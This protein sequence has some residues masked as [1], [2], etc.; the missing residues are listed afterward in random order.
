MRSLGISLSLI[1]IMGCSGPEKMQEQQPNNN[2]GT[3]TQFSADIWADNWFSLDINDQFIFEDSVPITTEKSFNK[4]S[5]TFEANYPFV[6]AFSLKDY[7]AN[8]TGLEYIGAANQQMG[9]GGF[10]AQ[11][12]ESQTGKAVA[13]SDG[14]WKCMV[15]HR[16]PLNVEC[17]KSANPAAE[18]QF[19]ALAEPLGWKAL[20]F[21][22]SGWA[23]ALKYT[24][25]EVGPKEGYLE[26]TW[27]AEA[28]LIWSGSLKQDNT[29]LCR[30]VVEAPM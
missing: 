2:M 21:D 24:E 14:T 8:D 1:F 23:N 3:N 29:L 9:D 11:V 19:E 28:S 10:I 18:C 17:E 12:H 16:A 30:V 4:E 15:I 20:D 25:A 7:K 6:M 27:E 22:A 13:L 26:V 5:F